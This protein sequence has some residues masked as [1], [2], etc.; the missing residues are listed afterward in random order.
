[1][2]DEVK[3]IYTGLC[4]CGC[5]CSFPSSPLPSAPNSSNKGVSSERGC[6]LPREGVWIKDWM[7]S[8]GVWMPRRRYSS[9]SFC[10]EILCTR[11]CQRIL[12]PR[13]TNVEDLARRWSPSR[14]RISRTVP[15]T[16]G[17]Y[18]NSGQNCCN[19]FT[20][21]LIIRITRSRSSRDD[22]LTTLYNV[23]TVTASRAHI[24][25]RCSETVG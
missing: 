23:K 14:C 6:T 11:R 8:N 9:S 3:D 5:G 19:F 12:L 13:P 17:P 22:L 2:R 15:F 16:T 20:H 10:Y 25:S 21:C 18:R 4:F 1:M 24:T 7:K